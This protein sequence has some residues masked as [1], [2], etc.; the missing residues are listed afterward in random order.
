MISSS[1]FSLN[2]T[3]TPNDKGCSGGEERALRLHPWFPPPPRL[4]RDRKQAR[5]AGLRAYAF[6]VWFQ[7][8]KLLEGGMFLRSVTVRLRCGGGLLAI[9]VRTLR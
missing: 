2:P 4:R 9:K 8:D 6:C 3:A 1:M 7:P 5:I